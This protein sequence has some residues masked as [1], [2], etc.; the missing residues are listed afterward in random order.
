[1]KL[2]LKQFFCSVFISLWKKKKI[3]NG[4]LNKGCRRPAIRFFVLVVMGK[5]FLK[6]KI[7]IESWHLGQD[8]RFDR[9]IFTEL[10]VYLS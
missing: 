3:E 8:R 1:M 5:N 6:S 4:V 9:G 7:I 10:S 2:G